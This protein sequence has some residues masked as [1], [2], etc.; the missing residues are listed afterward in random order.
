MLANCPVCGE[1]TVIRDE[2]VRIH[3]LLRC[4]NCYARLQIAEEYPVKLDVFRSH[5]LAFDGGQVRAVWSR[6]PGAVEAPE[7]R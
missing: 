2:G 4:P 6:E 5:G 1:D 7:L 3:R